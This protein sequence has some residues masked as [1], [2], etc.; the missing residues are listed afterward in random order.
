[1]AHD[2]WINARHTQHSMQKDKLF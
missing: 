2:A 1:M